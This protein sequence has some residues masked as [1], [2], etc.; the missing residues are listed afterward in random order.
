[1]LQQITGLLLS[2]PDTVA[3][4]VYREVQHQWLN[5]HQ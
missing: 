3:E 5:W 2:F 4:Q 1:M